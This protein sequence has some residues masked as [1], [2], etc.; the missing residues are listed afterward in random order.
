MKKFL[1]MLTVIVMM[2]VNSNVFAQKIDPNTFAANISHDANK[3]LI[4]KVADNLFA[5]DCKD[6][7]F[8]ASIQRSKIIKTLKDYNTLNAWGY[9]KI[10]Q[11]NLRS[12]FID[13]SE[14][15]YGDEVKGVMLEYRANDDGYGYTLAKYYPRSIDKFISFRGMPYIKVE[16]VPSAPKT[17]LVVSNTPPAVAQPLVSVPAS[18]PAPVAQVPKPAPTQT[19]VAQQAPPNY[20]Y[21]N[22]VNSYNT[23]KSDSHDCSGSGCT[24]YGCVDL[25]KRVYPIGHFASQPQTYGTPYGSGGGVGVSIWW[26]GASYYPYN[27][28]WHCRS[29]NTRVCDNDYYLLCKKFGRPENCGNQ[30][31]N[32]YYGNHKTSGG[33]NTAVT[34]GNNSSNYIPTNSS[35]YS[36]P[37]NSGGYSQPSGGGNHASGQPRTFGVR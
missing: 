7:M 3:R 5:E 36:A 33:S 27:G 30:N 29:N 21:N 28:W 32:T 19:V 35:G 12:D 24:N 10:D 34:Y 1:N 2:A 8:P 23:D 4:A 20:Y 18:T 15:I 26:N 13:N 37:A 17:S 22:V 6:C 31:S 11:T 9:E 16:G 25:A 14:I